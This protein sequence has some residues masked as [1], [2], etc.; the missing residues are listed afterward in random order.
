LLRDWF[1]GENKQANELTVVFGIANLLACLAGAYLYPLAVNGLLTT[2]G[3]S[4]P[5]AVLAAALLASFLL[6]VERGFSCE[7]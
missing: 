2:T 4:I 5:R 3:Y 7:R 6:A 1:K